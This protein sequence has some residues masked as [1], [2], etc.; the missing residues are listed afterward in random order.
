LRGMDNGGK[1][2]ILITGGSDG[3]GKAIAEKLAT[4]YRVVILSPSENKVKSVADKF[5]C[6]YVVADVT[7][8]ESLRQAVKK[9]VDK[10]GQINC[11]VNSAGLWIQDE[12]DNNDP[13]LIEKVI[14][15]NNKNPEKATNE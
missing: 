1:K 15:V 13:Q 10:Y 11:L 4:E 14:K 3:L 12:V 6:D 9:I 8:Y 7:D 5:K 2:V